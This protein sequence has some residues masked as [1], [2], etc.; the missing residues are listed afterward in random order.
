MSACGANNSPFGAR[1][2]GWEAFLLSVVASSGL[3]TGIWMGA[4]QLHGEYQAMLTFRG[5]V[6]NAHF[7]LFAFVALAVAIAAAIWFCSGERPR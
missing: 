5:M 2:K 3:A 1:S 4:T 7:Y 6:Y